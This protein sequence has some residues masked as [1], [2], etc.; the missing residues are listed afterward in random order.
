M[1]AARDCQGLHSVI[2]RAGGVDADGSYVRLYFQNG[3]RYPALITQVAAQV[4]EEQSDPLGT[5]VVCTRGA[6]PLSILPG[7]IQLDTPSPVVLAVKKRP[8]DPF[9]WDPAGPYF[10]SH[11]ISV[12]PG[13]SFVMDIYAR[14]GTCTCAW[15]LVANLMV[16]GRA[17]TVVAGDGAQPFRTAPI[18]AV[19]SAHCWALDLSAT[20]PLLAPSSACG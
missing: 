5:Q 13:E 17:V 20:P 15:Q 8:G 16:N 1:K 14:S 3:T 12:S 4:L 18:D 19:P 9:G 10:Q 11:V 6:G 7:F 2:A